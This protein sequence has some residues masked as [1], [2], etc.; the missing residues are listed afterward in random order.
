MTLYKP[1]PMSTPKAT[2]P[3]PNPDEAHPARTWSDL[4]KRTYGVGVVGVVGIFRPP[5]CW[6]R[7]ERESTREVARGTPT[8]PTTPT[9]PT[10]R[11]ETR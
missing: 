6:S 11:E 3:T 8:M 1:T 9:R 5:F 10:R 4:Q 7:S 2:T